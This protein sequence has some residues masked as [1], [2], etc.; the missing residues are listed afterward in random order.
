VSPFLSMLFIRK[1]RRF[2]RPAAFSAMARRRIRLV[3]DTA[4]DWP[5]TMRSNGRRR[6]SRPP[7]RDRGLDPFG[8]RAALAHV[9]ELHDEERAR[10]IGRAHE[11]GIA[12]NVVDLL[13]DVH[14]DEAVRRLLITELRV[15]DLGT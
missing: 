5:V 9:L 7:D 3:P 8:A 10:E 4:L 15:A 13:I 12:P 1:R 11:R 6:D 2:R 14:G